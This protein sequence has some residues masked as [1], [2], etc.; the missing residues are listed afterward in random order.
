M[1]ILSQFHHMW[2]GTQRG[3]RLIQYDSP[4]YLVEFAF[5]DSGPNRREFDSVVKYVGPLPGETEIEMWERLRECTGI[6]LG[7]PFGPSQMESLRQDQA[8]NALDLTV[9]TIDKGDYLVLTPAGQ[10]WNWLHH[11]EARPPV[12]MKMLEAGVDVTYGHLD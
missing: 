9:H 3:W 10:H 1:E 2:D 7:T 6:A 8:E 11:L 5:D 4:V 12:V